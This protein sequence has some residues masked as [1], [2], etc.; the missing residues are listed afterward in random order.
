MEDNTPIMVSKQYLHQW[1]RYDKPHEQ[2]KNAVNKTFKSKMDEDV[3]VRVDALYPCIEYWKEDRQYEIHY[4]DI[5]STLARPVFVITAV[6][7]NYNGKTFVMD[8]CIFFQRFEM[9]IQV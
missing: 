3:I 4:T 7:G 2:C 6:S 9:C 5:P 1:Y 8:A